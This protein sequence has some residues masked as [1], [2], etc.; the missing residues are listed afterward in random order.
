M[1]N[2]HQRKLFVCISNC[3]KQNVLLSVFVMGLWFPFYFGK[4][5]STLCRTVNLLPNQGGWSVAFIGCK[6]GNFLS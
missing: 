3:A 5:E 1:Y 4:D 2:K 6:Q